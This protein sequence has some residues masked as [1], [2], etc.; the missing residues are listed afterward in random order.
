MK[1]RELENQVKL[2]STKLKRQIDVINSE[3]FAGKNKITAQFERNLDDLIRENTE[4]QQQEQ[5]MMEKVKK[6]QAKRKKELNEGKQLYS[7]ATQG[8][9]FGHTEYNKGI[10]KHEQEQQHVI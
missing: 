10:R 8:G 9:G 1:Q 7:V 5:D 6:M 3:R 2:I 4:L